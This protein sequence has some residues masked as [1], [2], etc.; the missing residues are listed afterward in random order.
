[1]SQEEYENAVRD[2]N[3]RCVS[4]NTEGLS[5]IVKAEKQSHIESLQ[6]IKDKYEKAI[7]IAQEQLPTLEGQAKEECESR[8]NQYREAYNKELEN[9]NKLYEGKMDICNTKYPEL[10]NQINQ[11]TGEELQRGEAHKQ[12]MLEN[13]KSQYDNLSSITES[14]W[15]TMYNTTNGSL[16]NIAVTVDETT[17][18]ITG[19]Y[20]TFSGNVGAYTN[21]IASDVKNIADQHNVTN[22][23]VKNALNDMANNTINASGQICDAD[24]TIRDVNEV[25]DAIRNIPGSKTVTIKTLFEA[26]GDGIKSIFGFANGTDNAPAGVAFVAEEGQELILDGRRAILTG[27]SGPQLYNFKGG[28]KVITAPETKKLL[29]KQVNGGFFNQN[30]T[31][32]KQLIN[33]T[34]NNY[35][36]SYSNNFNMN[37]IAQMIAEATAAAVA[38]A[39]SNVTLKSNVYFN[40]NALVDRIGGKLAATRRRIR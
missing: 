3:Q 28:E 12:E 25:Q 19:I 1:M 22:S 10:M 15:Y 35:N 2:F 39:M 17:G 40:E 16:Q 32:S 5:E 23:Q 34:T 37:S 4:Y 33:N 29:S 9:A 14:G 24:G 7:S 6:A 13:L 11:Y 18:E 36:S 20:D 21:E 27:D 31:L 8:L 38:N 30:S 26:I